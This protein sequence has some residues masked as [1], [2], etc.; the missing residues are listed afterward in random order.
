MISHL[1]TIRDLPCA[2]CE[3]LGRKQTDPTEAHHVRLWV[4]AAQRNHDELTIPA[5]VDCHRG[6]NGIHGDKSLMRIAN[7]DEG[8]LLAA[9]LRKMF[10][11]KPAKVTP[12]KRHPKILPRNGPEAA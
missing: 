9:T 1:A 4:G 5:C 7:M 3:A 11:H 10:G 8:D 2:L 6:P 12:F